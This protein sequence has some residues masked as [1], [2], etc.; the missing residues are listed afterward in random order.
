MTTI[1]MAALGKS[2]MKLL[3]EMSYHKSHYAA[4]LID[5]LPGYKIPINGTFFREFVVQCPISP[6]LVNKR[7]MDQGI[8]GG[9]D[10]SD[11][12]ENGML[13]CVTDVNTKVEIDMLVRSLSKIGDS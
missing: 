2:G 1:Y 3:A 11:R 9:L 5:Q 7:L 8:I 4:S 6:A 12:Y 10:V 13:I